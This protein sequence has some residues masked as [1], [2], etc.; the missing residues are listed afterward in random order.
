[1]T[2]TTEEATETTYVGPDLNPDRSQNVPAIADPAAV[3]A[4]FEEFNLAVRRMLGIEDAS[5]GEVELFFHVCHKSGLDPFNKEVYM[6]GRNTQVTEWV[7]VPETG[8]RRKETRWVTRYTIQTGING[9]R[10][11]AREIADAKG[12]VFTQDEPLWCGEDAVWKPVWVDK[13]PPVAAKFTVYRDGEPFPFIAHFDEYVQMSGSGA[14]AA[15]NSMWKKMPRNQIR[16]CAEAGAIQAAFPDEFAGVLLE[17]A[18][19]NEPIVLEQ[20]ADGTFA[21]PAEKPARRRGGKGVGGLADRAAAAQNAQEPVVV[22]EEGQLD[23]RGPDPGEQE[24]ATTAEPPTNG[25]VMGDADWTSEQQQKPK[26]A[27]RKGLEKRL[28]TLLGDA[29]VDTGKTR[30]HIDIYRSVLEDDAITSTND[31]DDVAVKTVSDKLYGW[32]QQGV[33]DVEIAEILHAAT[34]KDDNDSEGDS[35]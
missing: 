5:D 20:D 34:L 23:D 22:D 2:T 28:F 19:Q 15:P 4:Q 3:P 26:T 25:S 17:D 12:V 1:M 14:D 27:K 29:K 32:Q 6:I 11:R 30:H 18:V 21:P 10:K 16:K 24:T 35:K 31:L 9:F 8:N 13:K 7:D 33:L